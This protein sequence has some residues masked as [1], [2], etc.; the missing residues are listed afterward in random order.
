MRHNAITARDCRIG[1][2]V[3]AAYRSVGVVFWAGCVS[4]A[5]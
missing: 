3:S 2:E 5:L 1:S 4:I